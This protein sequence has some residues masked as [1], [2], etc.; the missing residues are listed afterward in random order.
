MIKY[1]LLVSSLLMSGIACAAEDKWIYAGGNSISTKLINPSRIKV[2]NRESQIVEFWN[3]TV[4]KK[5]ANGMFK[6]GDIIFAKKQ[7]DCLNKKDKILTVTLLSGEETPQTEDNPYVS[8]SDVVP[9]SVA[10][11]ILKTI[12]NPIFNTSTS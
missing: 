7:V 3:K 11:E 8:W 4:Y 10:E 9:E 12:C 2:I 6:T 5:P 1:I